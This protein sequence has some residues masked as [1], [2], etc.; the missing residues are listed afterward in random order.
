MWGIQSSSHQ[1]W[2]HQ[3]KLSGTL[4]LPGWHH[5]QWCNSQQG[6]W[7]PLVQSH[8]FLWKTIK[9]SRA[10]SLAPPFHKNPVIR[11]RRRSHPPGFSIGSRSGYWSGFVKTACTPSLASNGKTICQTKK[12]S[13]EP[14]CPAYSPSCFRCICTGLA[15]SQGRKTQT[16]PKQSSSASSKNESAIVVLQK[17]V[18]K[19]SWRDSFYRLESAISHGSRRPQTETAGAHQWG[20]PVV[21]SR[22]RDLKPQRKNAGGRKSEQ[23]P[24][25]P[26]SKFLSVQSAVR[27]AHQKLISTATNEHARIDY[28]PSQQ[29]SSVRNKP[30]CSNHTTFKLQ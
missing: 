27:A 10:E 19:I 28:Q 18:I 16:I 29:L 24:Y 13:R 9:D 17:I 25:H 15:T 3:P 8:H 7:Q 30:S 4:H 2:W 1:H 11:G 23:H 21:S 5:L 6:S 14:A 22:Q 20:K 12:S 26:H